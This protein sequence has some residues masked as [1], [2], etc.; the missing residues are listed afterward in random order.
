[1]V[2]QAVLEPLWEVHRS[3]IR[4][5]LEVL[6]SCL[7]F[8]KKANE[9]NS[10]AH[11][12]TDWQDLA[13]EAKVAMIASC[14]LQYPFSKGGKSFGSAI[15]PSASTADMHKAVKR[16]LY[17]KTRKRK[18]DRAFNKTRKRFKE[19]FSKSERDQIG[20]GDKNISEKL[21]TKLKSWVGN[22]MPKPQEG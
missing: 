10:L 9:L 1:M 18:G 7:A 15:H 21:R 14:E 6:Q 8:L 22:H 2:L 20:S 19:D 13:F 3:N 16:K 17:T 5:E 4:E 11:S 12:G